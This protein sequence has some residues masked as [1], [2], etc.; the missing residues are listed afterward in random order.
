MPTPTKSGSEATRRPRLLASQS[1]DWYIGTV[2]VSMPVPMPVR[3]RAIMMCGTEKAVVWRTAPTCVYQS[4][5]LEELVELLTMI[6]T[7]AVHMASF[8]PV[9]S[10]YMNVRIHPLKHP[11]L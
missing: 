7:M 10:A 11:K 8:L 9:V 5:S 2:E 1:S 6:Q 3:K 4:M